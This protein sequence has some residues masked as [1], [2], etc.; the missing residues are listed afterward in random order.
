V[1]ILWAS[2]RQFLRSLRVLE[3]R[4][5]AEVARRESSLARVMVGIFYF[6]FS[7]SRW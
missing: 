7:F 4:F 1:E 5:N 3:K 2:F 6:L